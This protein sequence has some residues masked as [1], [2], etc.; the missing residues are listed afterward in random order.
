MKKT[1]STIA[2]TLLF[3][4]AQAQRNIN[5]SG[6]IKNSNLEE[7]TYL[8]LE[9]GYQLLDI[10]DDGSFSID[11]KVQQSPS[12]YSIATASKNGKIKFQS[13]KI[14]FDKDSVYLEFDYL[15]KSIEATSVLPFQSYSEKI[16]L[17]KGQKKI[18]LILDK[19]NEI[20]SLYFAEINKEKTPIED[21]K[22]YY[23][24][25][26]TQNK[27]SIYAKRI[28]N[29][30][31]AIESPPLKKGEIF[32]NFELPDKN[33]QYVGVGSEQKKPQVIAVFS[34]G[35][36]YSLA[37]IDL[38]VQ[39]S[40]LNK[41]KIEIVSIWDDRSKEIWLGFDQEEKNKIT[42][43]NL[44]DEYG[45]A[46]TYLGNKMWPTFYLINDEGKLS[47]ILRGYDKKTAKGLKSFLEKT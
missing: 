35:C 1:V 16:E 45:F 44:L 11:G 25:L 28:E 5:F 10:S 33:G 13:H 36:A 27:G 39:L 31:S 17:S 37:S 34:T 8:V 14:W 19:P 47:Q 2:L 7:K 15:D 22:R 12:C 6:H 41:D 38:L 20:P 24:S 30:L 43:K 46:V 4:L 21:L 23:S 18:K 42:W 40:E 26:N 32:K 9:G 3:F 29:Y